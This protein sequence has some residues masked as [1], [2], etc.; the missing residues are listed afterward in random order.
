M[1][2]DTYRA[3]ASL[4]HAVRPC[5]P[6]AVVPL[7]DQGPWSVHQDE[8]EAGLA[9]LETAVKAVNDANAALLELM[10]RLLSKADRGTPKEI[11]ALASTLRD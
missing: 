5:T 9:E 8:I 1:N 7:E 6:M 11:D 2:A 10:R 4:W 3:T